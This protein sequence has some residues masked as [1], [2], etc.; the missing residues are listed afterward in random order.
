MR[1]FILVVILLL[2]LNVYDS[3]EC[4]KLFIEGEENN[5][6][7]WDVAVNHSRR[8]WFTYI[9][10]SIPRSTNDIEN[11]QSVFHIDKDLL[12][13][14]FKRQPDGG[15]ALLNAINSINSTNTGIMDSFYYDF[16]QMHNENHTMRIAEFHNVRTNTYGTIV[17]SDTCEYVRNGGCAYM[18]HDHI[19]QFPGKV[20]NINISITIGSGASGT[21]HY[22]MEGLV[23]LASMNETMLQSIKIISPRKESFGTTWL[24]LLDVKP[25]NIVDHD[26]IF[27]KTLY[28]PEMGLC[29]TP[30]ISQVK[31]MADKLVKKTNSTYDNMKK[32]TIILVERIGSRIVP[33]MQAVKR[34]VDAFAQKHGYDIILHQTNHLPTLNKQ[35]N[36]FVN[37]DIILSPHGAD[38]LFIAFSKHACVIEFLQP[39]EPNACYSRLAYINKLNYHGY[40]LNTS[41]NMDYEKVNMGLLSCQQIISRNSST[42]SNAIKV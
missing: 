37:A 6:F 13:E 15:Q 1:S 25:E 34:I 42:T 40:A 20:L 4:K 22:P 18:H 38:I 29:G 28:V 41:G 7:I 19:Y 31:W 36:Y 30:Y 26:N 21:W 33:N 16:F 35:I 39:R 10:T 24:K 27:S 11:A 9:N 32:K 12:L 8:T 23:A 3:K 2:T 5:Y 14:F 17:N